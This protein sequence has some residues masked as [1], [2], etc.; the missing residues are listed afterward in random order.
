MEVPT[1][2]RS[3]KKMG[4]TVRGTQSPWMAIP[5]DVTR[6]N[7]HCFKLNKRVESIRVVSTV[8]LRNINQFNV[9]RLKGYPNE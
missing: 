8:S 9:T 6:E 5:G 4:V 7:T 2:G 1:I 3:L